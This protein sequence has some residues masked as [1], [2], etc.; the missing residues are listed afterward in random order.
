M[1]AKRIDLGPK[2]VVE[3][4]LF[5]SGRTMSV[6]QLAEF[7]GLAPLAVR[8]ALTALKEEYDERGGALTLFEDPQGWRM[9]VRD[10][11]VPVVKRIVA[12]T[13]LS[14]ACM[15]TLAVIAYRQPK[16]IQSE[17]V[18]IRG[19]G[20]YEHL[21]ELERLGFIRRE[22]E[23]RSYAVKLTE[24]FYQ[25]FDVKG[26]KDIRD[27]FK[28]VKAPKKGAQQ[29]L[30]DLSVVDVPPAPERA[31][32]EPLELEVVDV[33]EQSAAQGLDLVEARKEGHDSEYLDDLDKRIARLQEI[34]KGHDEDPLLRRVGDSDTD[35]TADE[36]KDA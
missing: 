9:M 18:D 5:A 1:I 8:G 32:R 29:T 34:N 27:V 10:P 4:L 2:D 14:R 20:A 19:G 11:F 28:G 16:A 7:T 33:A 35:E 36:V 6:E 13:E 17:V 30:G 12:D 3:A 31:A 26:G 22:P 21:A 15:E 25:Y 23:G 24:K